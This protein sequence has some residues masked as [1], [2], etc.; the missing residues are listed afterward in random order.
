[1]PRFGGWQRRCAPSARSQSP[2]FRISSPCYS[3]SLLVPLLL[4]PPRP[5]PPL[6]PVAAKPTSQTRPA[7]AQARRHVARGALPWL[8][9]LA[10]FGLTYVYWTTSDGTTPPPAAPSLTSPAAPTGVT[11][12]PAPPAA[13]LSVSTSPE[14]NLERGAALGLAKQ[15]LGPSVLGVLPF[16]S[17]NND[18]QFIAVLL[19]NP[20]YAPSSHFARIHPVVRILEGGREVFNLHEQVL[21]AGDEFASD[22]AAW[23]RLVVPDPGRR[24]SGC[25]VRPRGRRRR[26]RL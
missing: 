16:R 8:L 1:M 9:A 5:S 25:A 17:R 4:R 11:E 20:E 23:R 6:R 15:H 24:G 26:W 21:L 18:W 19:L 22:T 3:T 2:D 7:Q 12:A 10:L 14:P 13:G